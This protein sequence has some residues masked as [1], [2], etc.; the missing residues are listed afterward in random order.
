MR[1]AMIIEYDG[2]DYSGWQRQK[3][4]ISVQQ[5]IEEAL[6]K[7]FIKKITIVGS[8]RTDKGVHAEGQVAHFDAETDLSEFKIKGSLNFFLPEDIKIREIKKVADDFHAQFDAKSKIYVF[9]TYIS[10]VK[11]PLKSRYY[12]QIIP[13]LDI[14]LMRESAKQIV[15]KHDFSSFSVKNGDT[16]S[17]TI[18]QIS[19]I[20]IIEKG[21]TV[22]FEV[23][24]PGFLYKMV[25]SIVGTLIWIGRGKLSPDCIEKMF[26][27][28]DRALGG[29]T[30][31]A[32]GLVLKKVIYA[33]VP[34]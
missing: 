2:T 29:K 32:N 31:A 16:P 21:D 20:D 12:V 8:G 28:G 33:E 14:E 26:S 34:K 19:R 5:K 30:L 11:S 6:E 17:T 18:R 24:G 23:E 7:L 10:R 3:N 27:S 13:P 15:G 4:G 9:N 22:I 25:R 1:F